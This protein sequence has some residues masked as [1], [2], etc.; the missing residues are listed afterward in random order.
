M[1]GVFLERRK[2]SQGLWKGSLKP[3]HASSLADPSRSL[4]ECHEALW[5]LPLSVLGSQH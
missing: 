3:H 5:G 2:R 1:E 4:L